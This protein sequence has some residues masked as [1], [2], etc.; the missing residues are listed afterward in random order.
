MSDVYHQELERQAREHKQ[1]FHEA[2]GGNLN[3]PMARL[4]YNK[5]QR[6]EDMAQQGHNLRGIR[7]EIRATERLVEQAKHAPSGYISTDHANTTYHRLRD[8]GDQIGRHP[9]FQ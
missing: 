7:D 1:Q 6:V 2:V 9:H 8:W 4:I 5:M 3:D